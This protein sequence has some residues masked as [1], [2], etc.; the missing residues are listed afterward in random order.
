LHFD[1]IFGVAHNINVKNTQKLTPVS[2]IRLDVWYYA[3]SRHILHLLIKMR[4]L[5]PWRWH[6]RYR[7]KDMHG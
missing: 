1:I 4:G 7:T 6:F 5:S 2:R 3:H